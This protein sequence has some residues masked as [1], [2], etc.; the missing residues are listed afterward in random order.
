MRL[1]QKILVCLFIGLGL[2]APSWAQDDFFP[3]A[4]YDP[5]IP[6]PESYLGYEIGDILVRYD[7]VTGY[8]HLLAERSDRI[9]IET[10][11]YSHERRPIKRLIITHPDNHARLDEIQAQHLRLADPNENVSTDDMP[12]VTWI[13]YG[14]HGDEISGIEA[15]LGIAYHLA[16]VQDEA[17][18]EVL[19][20]SIIL[21]IATFNPDGRD[22]SAI[23]Y[24]M[25]NARVPVSDPA[26]RE[27]FIPWPGG[28]TN[29]YWFDLNRQWLPL[30][31][32]EA[33]AWIK[34]YHDWKPN[35]VVDFHEMGADRTYYFHPGEQG[36]TYPHVPANAERLL[37]RISKY[38]A[39]QLDEEQL[40]YFTS[41]IFDNYYI[42]KGSTFPLVTGGVGML[43]EQSGSEGIVIESDHG[44]NVFQEN[45]RQHMNSGLAVIQ[46]AYEM[47]RDFV[48]HQKTFF[49]NAIRDA[50]QAADKA[51]VFA[52][53]NDPLRVEFFL[54]LLQQHQIKA[55]RLGR[56]ISSE[57]KTFKSGEAYVV[58][59]RQ[60]HYRLI[61]GIFDRLTEFPRDSFYDISGWTLPYAFGLDFASLQR[62]RSDVL[63]GEWTGSTHQ[64]RAPQED[65]VAY[66]MDWQG[67]YA[68]RALYRLLAAG[69]KARATTLP[70][71]AETVD[72]VKTFLPGTI[73]ISAG[74]NEP[75]VV[76]ALPA[77]FETIAKEDGITIE[78]ISAGLTP[79]GPDIGGASQIALEV[80]RVA[81]ITGSGMG[82]YDSGEI[83]HLLDHRMNLPVV[84]RDG[85]RFAG[86]QLSKYTHIILADGQPPLDERQIARLRNWVNEGGTLIAT[87]DAGFW[88]AKHG[89]GSAKIGEEEAEEGEVERLPFAEQSERE[90][91]H[92]I[93]G[94]VFMTEAD[95]THPVAFGLTSAQLPVHRDMESRF[96]PHENPYAT[97]AAYG[98][99]PL[100]SGYASAENKAVLAGTPAIIAES[101][102]RGAVVLFAD[103]PAFRGYWYGTNKLL[104]NAIFF[105]DGF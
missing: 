5:N 39:A 69:V 2:I 76:E 1:F 37:D 24:N 27:H 104:M 50:E 35:M 32:P 101:M 28:R 19:R 92:R 68:P 47:R 51:Y 93:A 81:M 34:V 65:A 36:R 100:V 45:I 44:L 56:D 85:D 73:V 20:N 7:Q 79:S 80:P 42:G 86:L 82:I 49:R 75:S 4:T 70:M 83:W 87:Q 94:A 91:K 33:Q 72:G 21:N 14:V 16:A 64:A 59:V 60:P 25:H 40:P 90:A 71:T 43:F 26:H 6:T 67:Y 63:G 77:L 10:I 54:T 52:A 31:Q 11:G 58:P 22:R 66:A 61:R 103:N 84:L 48:D 3:D 53:P 15:V 99:D 95:I 38:P 13:N 102:G 105:S 17:W 8:L 12:V 41:E 62:L 97:V 57:G 78:A 55:Y 96:A 98:D 89:F 30:T 46:G 23:W 74:N 29:H 88:A 9:T 18:I